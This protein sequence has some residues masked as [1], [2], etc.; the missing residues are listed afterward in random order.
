M[1]EGKAL[2]IQDFR[3]KQIQLKYPCVLITDLNATTPLVVGQLEAGDIPLIAEYNN[4]KRV[5]CNISNSAYNIDKLLRTHEGIQYLQ[6][7]SS[8]KDITNIRDY[9]EVITGWT[10]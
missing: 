5:V 6:S 9:L 7:E 1:V 8:F 2:D 4:V 3:S 10:L